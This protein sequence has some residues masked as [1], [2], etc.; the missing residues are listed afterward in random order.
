M[1]KDGEYA[2]QIDDHSENTLNNHKRLRKRSCKISRNY[3]SKVS[4]KSTR[5]SES[6]NVCP[7]SK[8]SVDPQDM[9]LHSDDSSVPH[10]ILCDSSDEKTLCCT[11]CSFKENRHSYNGRRKCGT[12]SIDVHDRTK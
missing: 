2:S 4:S 7:H 12:S 1:V 5:S 8:D 6:Q 9:C 10:V 3:S 11:Y